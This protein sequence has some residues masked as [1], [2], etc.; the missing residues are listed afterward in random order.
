[1]PIFKTK[2]CTE[3]PD[4]G[5]RGV[6]FVILVSFGIALIVLLVKELIG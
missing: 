5:K 4:D 3:P 2:N 1:M 6:A